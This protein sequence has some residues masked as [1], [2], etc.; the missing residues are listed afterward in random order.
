MASIAVHNG[1]RMLTGSDRLGINP[2]VIMFNARAVND[3]K[4]ALQAMYKA[5]DKAVDYLNNTDKKEYMELVVQ[6]NSFPKGAENYLKLPKY[7]KATQVE[8]D[9]VDAVM[10]W[11]LAKKLIK[12]VF[13]LNELSAD[14][15]A[16]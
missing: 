5:Y 14:V 2:G 8:K 1:C 16:K 13:T 4:A 15:L 10:N 11:M 9:E 3:K 6:K 12:Q 7:H